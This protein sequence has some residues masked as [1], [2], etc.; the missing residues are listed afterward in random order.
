MRVA[1]LVAILAVAVL[2]HIA[3][4]FSFLHLG[5]LLIAGLDTGA[6][7]ILTVPLVLF[8]CVL[9]AST[10]ILGLTMLVSRKD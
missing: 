6:A 8:V 10:S 3:A 4:H 9:A 2:L 7:R 1:A 5:E